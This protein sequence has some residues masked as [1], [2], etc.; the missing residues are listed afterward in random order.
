MSQPGWAAQ[1]RTKSG[2]DAMF[3]VYPLFVGADVAQDLPERGWERIL[4][5]RCER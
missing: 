3:F 4:A 1:K 5:K 2:K